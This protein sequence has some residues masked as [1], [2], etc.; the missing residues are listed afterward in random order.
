[1]VPEEILFVGFDGSRYL[2]DWRDWPELCRRDIHARTV[3]G[4]LD[5]L[6]LTADDCAWLW[7]MGVGTGEATRLLSEQGLPI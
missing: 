1:M 5:C 7:G 4:D 2:C 6:T 3:P